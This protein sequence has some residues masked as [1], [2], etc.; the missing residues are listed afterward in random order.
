MRAESYILAIDQGTTGT[1]ALLID[2]VGS[3]VASGYREVSP[4]E[5]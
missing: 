3:P 1:T 5:I 4:E 2:S